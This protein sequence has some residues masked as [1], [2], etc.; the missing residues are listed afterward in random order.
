MGQWV[1]GQNGDH[2]R[3]PQLSCSDKNQALTDNKSFSIFSAI[4]SKNDLQGQEHVNIL[5]MLKEEKPA[6]ALKTNSPKC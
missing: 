4:L 1:T 2:P 3:K 6:S 5:E